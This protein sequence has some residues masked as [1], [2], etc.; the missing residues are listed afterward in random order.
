MASFFH[1]VQVSIY[2]IDICI[3]TYNLSSLY[4]VTCINLYTGLSS[5]RQHP[6]T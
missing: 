4:N 5:W 2:L 1:P 3:P 6:V